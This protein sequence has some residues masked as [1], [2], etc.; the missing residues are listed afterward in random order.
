MYTRPYSSPAPQRAGCCARRTPGPRSGRPCKSELQYPSRSCSRRRRRRDR[1]RSRH[2]YV[3]CVA[4]AMRSHRTRGTRPR[5]AY[6]FRR[7]G[8]LSGAPA[9]GAAPGQGAPLPCV[10][11]CELPATPTA[12]TRWLYS[13][14]LWRVQRAHVHAYELDHRATHA[15]V[16]RY[17]WVTGA[18][19]TQQRNAGGHI[20]GPRMRARTGCSA[21][22]VSVMHAAHACLVHLPMPR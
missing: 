14:G 9:D 3:T 4:M 7:P 11:P 2:A 15:K 6:G 21:R 16:R 12:C 20:H 8:K 10:L 13:V 5:H 17:R 22:H 1:R 18:A 19:E